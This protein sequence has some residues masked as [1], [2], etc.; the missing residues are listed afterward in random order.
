MIKIHFS[1]PQR[2]ALAVRRI[3]RFPFMALQNPEQRPPEVDV[4]FGKGRVPKSRFALKSR[5]EEVNLSDAPPCPLFLPWRDAHSKG[6]IQP[7]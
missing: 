2:G 7:S 4:P 3:G 1:R 6:R 5:M